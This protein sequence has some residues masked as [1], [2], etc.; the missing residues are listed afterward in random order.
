MKILIISNMAAGLLNLRRELI[1]KLLE[2]SGVYICV[3]IDEYSS[4]IT[5]VGANLIGIDLERRGTN[6]FHEL[7]SYK[8]Y[9]KIIRECNPDVVLTYTIKPNIY[10]GIVCR[11]QKVPYICNITGLGTELQGSSFRAKVMMQIY[12]YSVKKAS[13]VYVQNTYILERFNKCKVISNCEVLPGSGVNLKKHYYEEYPSEEDGIK[14]LYIGRLMKDKGSD[15]LIYAAEKIARKYRNT[16]FDVVGTFEE[17]EYEEIINRLSDKG[18]MKYYPF[19][20]NIHEI[21]KEHHCIIHP[22]YHEGMSNALLEAA[23]VG[24]PVIATNIPGCRETFDDE[25]TG[26]EVNVKDKDSL[27]LGIEKFLNMTPQ[28]RQEMGFNGRIKVEKE[29]DRNI[30]VNKY[31]EKIREIVDSCNLQDVSIEKT[32]S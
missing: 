14:F 8:K 25:I 11:R 19:Q 6:P 24:R 31:I 2:I 29:F 28:R 23:A 10:G 1:E 4:S 5:D 18:I 3:P 26:I 7:S 15:E 16:R 20:E 32:Q 9:K 17:A 21:I 27:V 12:A 13:K 22:S 30:I